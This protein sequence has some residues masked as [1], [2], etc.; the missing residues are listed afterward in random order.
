MHGTDPLDAWVDESIARSRA[1]NY[2]PTIFI[3]MRERYGTEQAMEKIV[4]SGVM[5]SGFIR[6]KH[7]GM[8]EDWSIEAGILLFRER[9]TQDAQNCAQFRLEHIDDPI[10]RGR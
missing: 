5:Q 6:L 9:F 10:L 2:H 1:R 3:R 4:R 7:L 8:A